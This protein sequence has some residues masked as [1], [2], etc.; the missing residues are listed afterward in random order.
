VV[1][2]DEG[3]DIVERPEAV[4]AAA[5]PW[6]SLPPWP[7][8]PPLAELKSSVEALAVHCIRRTRTSRR[9]GRCRRWRPR[10]RCRQSLI[11]GTTE[12]MSITCEPSGE[13]PA[14]APKPDCQAAA[15]PVPR[16]A[17]AA[18]A[19][20][21]LIAGNEAA[22]DGGSRAARGVDAAPKA[23]PASRLPSAA[24]TPAPP[25]PATVLLPV[26]MQFVM[27]MVPLRVLEMPP[28]MA[29]PPGPRSWRRP[30]RRCL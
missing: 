30:G 25:C 3:G 6:P 5:I 21:G 11:A 28:P 16:I 8:S 15:Q 26:T 12:L 13:K 19:A 24:L 1:V 17:A 7:S 10:R 18:R 4:D 14:R 22:A 23:K 2:G 27:F 20:D 9:P 29:S